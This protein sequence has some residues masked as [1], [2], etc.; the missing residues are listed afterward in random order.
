MP[1][2]QTR[3]FVALL[4]P[5]DWIAW[6]REVA[7]GMKPRSSGLSWVKPENAHFT[8]RFLG[9]LDDAELQ[10]V[11]D[12]VRRSGAPLVAPLARLGRLGAFPR[13][14]R[15][16]VLWVGLAQGGAETEAVAT[17]VNEAL[18]ADGFGPLDKPFRPHL[19]LAR[20]REGARGVADLVRAPLP[21][22]PPA[23]RLQHLAVM[24]SELHPSGAM[25]NVLEE[26]RL[27]SPGS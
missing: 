26:I 21:E 7:G 23:G 18:E 25:Y 27:L 8:V 16:R 5:D 17:A 6:V 24:K 10:R 3:T 2:E 4:I 20:A 13:P 19:T 22:A 9:N 1:A 12:S 15:P 14:E 11:R